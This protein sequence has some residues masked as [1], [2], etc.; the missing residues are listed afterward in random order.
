MQSASASHPTNTANRCYSR[1]PVVIN[2][3]SQASSPYLRQHA[4]NPVHWQQWHADTLARARAEDKPILVSI[5]YSTCH[6]CHVMERESFEDEA[7]AE[8]M[9]QHFVCIKVDREERPDVDR[10]YMDACQAINGSGGWPLN[11][12]LLPDGRPFYAGTYYPPERKYNRPS[13]TELLTHLAE[14]YRDDR[15]TVTD[16]A[17]RIMENIRGGGTRLLRLEPEAENHE[18][19]RENILGKLRATYDLKNG[20]FGGAPKFPGSQS[21]EVLL[22]HG[23]LHQEYND[24]HL[25]AH[26]MLAML[27]GGIYDQLGGGFSRYTVDGAWR[28]PHFEKMLYDNALLLRLLGKLQLVQPQQRF[29]DAIAETTEWLQREML[30]PTGG[31]RAALDADSE[32]VE[33]KYYVWTMDEIEALLSPDQARLVTAFYGLTSAGNWEEESTNIPYRPTT[34]AAVTAELDLPLGVARE[35]LSAAR[36]TLHDYRF[37]NRVHPGADD[38]L[39]LQWNALLISGWTWCYRATGDEKYRR[40]AT[41]LWDILH[42]QLQ[43]N[44]QWH[45]NLT[46]GDLGAPAFLDDLAALAEAALDLHDVT[47]DLQYIFGARAGAG[48]VSLA[49]NILDHFAASEGPMFQL[50]PTEGNELPL[51]SVDLFDNALPSGNSQM[52]S[53]LL[54]LARLTG[55][56]DFLQR[57]EEMLAAMAGSLERYPGSFG[58][59]LYAALLHAA[60]ERELA[61][62][63]PGARAAA[64]FFLSR[65]RPE[66]LIVA[67]ESPR[68]DVP[69]LTNRYLP[70]TLRFFVCENQACRLPVTSAEAAREQL[71]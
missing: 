50:R 62:T 52:M 1:N 22:T 13:W 5:G 23:V 64:A 65:Y 53:V 26:G 25:A 15:E 17:A 51:A 4:G 40:L 27:D 38:K 30:L 56:E 60:P 37:Q 71:S 48:S 70:D 36:Q 12:F 28:V 6:W 45:R 14:L 10:I 58:G 42:E 43:V 69:L 55:R 21:L 67:T 39:I 35:Q 24:Q 19:W 33:G 16:Q 31:Y 41:D 3:L 66:L 63:G 57:G 68:E 9:N 11:A 34:L 32:G 46:H 59:W 20:G 7:V 18:E 2:Q 54:R 49:E 61:V 47:F 8:L 29:L 44:G